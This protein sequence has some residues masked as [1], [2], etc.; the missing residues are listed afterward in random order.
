MIV[1]GQESVIECGLKRAAEPRGG[2][3][4]RDGLG[5]SMAMVPYHAACKRHN[6]PAGGICLFGE[7]IDMAGHARDSS[8]GV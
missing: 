7:D 1:D 3:D 4:S 5:E 8:L 6:S 2:T